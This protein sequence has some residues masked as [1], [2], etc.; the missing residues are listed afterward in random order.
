MLSPGLA[1][2]PLLVGT[3]GKTLEVVILRFLNRLSI[4]EVPLT[5][6]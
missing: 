6:K 4:R 1:S 3:A 2:E 5:F